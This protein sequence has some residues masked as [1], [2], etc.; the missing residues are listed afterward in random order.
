MPPDYRRPPPVKL[1]SHPEPVTVRAPAKLNLHLSVGLLRAD[2]FHDLTTVYQAV[3]LY[4]EVTASPAP[5]LSVSVR[6]EDAP[7]VPLDDGNLAVR[8]ARALAAAAGVEPLVRLDIVKAIPVAGGLAGGSADAAAALVA[9]DALWGTAMDRA[10]LLDLAAD[11]GSDVPFA[12]T[13]GTALG[14]GRGERL[15]PVLAIGRW[16]WVLAVAESGLSTPEVYRE[17]DRKRE[18]DVALAPEPLDSLINALRSGEPTSLGHALS[19][20]LQAAALSLRPALRRT[21][22]AGED[23]GSTGR[24]VSGSGPTCAFLASSSDDA[25]RLAAALSGA[26]VCR[27]VRAAYGPVAGARVVTTTAR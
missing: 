9:C 25:V 3:S 21:L 8:A 7:L 27:T 22:D 10:A 14:T 4:D 6:G 19:N 18:R 16:H 26:G 2:G 12:L 23:L 20:D 13:G 11:L 17:L 5:E 24:V 15:A 1:A